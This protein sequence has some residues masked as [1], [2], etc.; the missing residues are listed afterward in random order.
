[1]EKAKALLRDTDYKIY[2]IGEMVG[3]ENTKLFTRTF[4]ST[5]GISPKEY[6][7]RKQGVP[8]NEDF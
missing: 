1:M 7:E 3:Y 2:H 4:K 5:Y 6:R 8:H